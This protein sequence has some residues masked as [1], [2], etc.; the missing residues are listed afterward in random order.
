MGKNT[1][2]SWTTSTANFW[3]GCM[4]VSSGCKYCYAETLADGRYNKGI[5]GPAPHTLRER[6]KG[7]WKD[8][9]RWNRK[10]ADQEEP[11]YVFV[12]SMSDFFEDH[13]MVEPW[14]EEALA[15]ISECKNL[16]FQLLTKRPQNVC[17]MIEAG[18]GVEPQEWFSANPHVWVGTSV[19]DQQ[20]ADERIPH[21][22]LIPAS[23]RFLSCEPL[24]G[25]IVLHDVRYDSLVTINALKG[26]VSTISPPS[27]SFHEANIKAWPIDWVIVGGESGKDARP[28]HARWARSLRDQCLKAGVPFFFKQWGEWAPV[29]YNVMVRVGKEKAGDLLDGRQWH[30]FPK[31]PKE[32]VIDLAE[33]WPEKEEEKEGENGNK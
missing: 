4:K 20:R 11:W 25:P 22:L 32:K 12:Q 24:L 23:V 19:E 1:G 15:L 3:W 18:A 14:R 21:L 7:I 28:M 16:T 8:L 30:Q 13:P 17:E 10:A 5:W 27:K 29:E 31:F 33:L 2:I 26:Y 6:K 9:P